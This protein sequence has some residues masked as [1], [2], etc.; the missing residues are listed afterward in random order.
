MLTFYPVKTEEEI[1]M[2][3]HHVRNEIALLKIRQNKL[4]DELVENK[5]SNN[6]K[7]NK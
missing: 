2:E 7:E 6:D 5:G 1:I 3:L 4:I